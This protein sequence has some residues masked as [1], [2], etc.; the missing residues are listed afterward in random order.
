MKGQGPTCLAGGPPHLFNF[1]IAVTAMLGCRV[2]SV[3]VV[4]LVPLPWL[5][6]APAM[7]FVGSEVALKCAWMVRT[8]QIYDR[9]IWIYMDLL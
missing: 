9:S 8:G 3:D 4:P 6:V 5:P 2:S 1:V 7:G